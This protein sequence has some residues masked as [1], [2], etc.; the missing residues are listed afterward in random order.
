MSQVIGTSVSRSDG[1]AKVTGAATYSAEH[2]L[3]NL[4]HGYVV[5][6]TIASGEIRHIDISEAGSCPGVIA[7]FT[8]LN[9]PKIFTPTNNFAKSKIYEARLPLS[10]NQVHYAGQIIGLVVADTFER[11]R[12]AASRVKVDYSPQPL[13]IDAST[14]NFKDAPPSFGEEMKFSTGDINKGMANATTKVVETYHTETELHA[15]M[16]PHAIIV[17]W[18]DDEVNIYEHSQFVI[19]SQRTYSELLGVPTEKVRII[20]PYI[21]GGFG[22]KAFPWSHAILCAAAAKEIKRPL[23][24]VLSRRQMTALVGHR[25]ETEQII[26]LGATADGTITAIDHEVKSVT[27]PVDEFTEG[28]TSVTPAMYKTDNLRLMQE[29]GVM[30]VGVP[31]FMRAPGENPGMWALESTLR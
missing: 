31:T 1:I 7:V 19:G 25:S 4:V 28:C 13:V 15:P 3:P 14:A 18:L 11:A 10:D 26:R 22:S 8:H 27:S 9:A 23:K 6:S 17:D 5:T 16:E 24:V 12:D 21:G 29:L 2:K 30:N 20:S